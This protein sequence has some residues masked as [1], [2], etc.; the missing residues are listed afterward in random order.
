VHPS[1]LLYTYFYPILKAKLLALG[2][3]DLSGTT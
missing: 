3:H 1:E 2:F